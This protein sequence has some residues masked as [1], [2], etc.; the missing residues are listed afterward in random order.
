MQAYLFL[1]GEDILWIAIGGV[2]NQID[3]PTHSP[4]ALLLLHALMTPAMHHAASVQL[5]LYLLIHGLKLVC[6]VQ[7]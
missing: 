1:L 2:Q 7:K 6:E 4:Q 3:C 5:L